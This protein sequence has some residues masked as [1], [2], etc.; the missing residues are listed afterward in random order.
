[1]NIQTFFLLLCQLA[2]SAWCLECPY[3]PADPQQALT[4]EVILDCKVYCAIE[5]SE[6]DPEISNPGFNTTTRL[7]GS[8][9]VNSPQQKDEDFE[10]GDN[11]DGFVVEGRTQEVVCNENQE[12]NKA[13][14]VCVWKS[15]WKTVTYKGKDYFWG[16]QV[17]QQKIDEI[18]EKLDFTSDKLF[19]KFIW[20]VTLTCML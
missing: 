8:L 13:Y 10:F 14:K 5:L 17:T 9:V 18:S 1:M 15:S 12:L 7:C 4:D 16:S 19:S 2:L 6:I 3:A 20:W 11:D